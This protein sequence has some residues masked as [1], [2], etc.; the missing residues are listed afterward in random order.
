MQHAYD[1]AK[2][3]FGITIDKSEIDDKVATGPRKPTRG[4]TNSYRLKGDKGTVRV[5]VYNMGNKF[6]LNMYKEEVE[7]QEKKDYKY[8]K[9][10]FVN[11]QKDKLKDISDREGYS[12]IELGD[13]LAQKAGLKEPDDLYF[14]GNELVYGAKTIALSLIHI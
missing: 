2:K 9:N 5:Q 11:D 8:S 13:Y 7:I 3:K 6:E 14:D 10:F 4:K 12:E 1:H